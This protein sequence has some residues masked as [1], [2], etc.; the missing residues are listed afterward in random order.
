M[1]GRHLSRGCNSL[2]EFS[3]HIF[4]HISIKVCSA[5]SCVLPLHQPWSVKAVNFV[6]CSL[7]EVGGLLGITF[8]VSQDLCGHRLPC[9][10][11]YKQLLSFCNFTQRGTP[12]LEFTNSSPGCSVVSVEWH[13]PLQSCFGRD[14]V[15]WHFIMNSISTF[16]PS[17]AVLFHPSVRFWKWKNSIFTGVTALCCLLSRAW[18]D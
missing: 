4:S 11:W 14:F 16:S 1:E 2:P 8:H 12:P 3:V 15:Y 7:P 10:D 13:W 18:E 5:Y 17:S 9:S 6:V